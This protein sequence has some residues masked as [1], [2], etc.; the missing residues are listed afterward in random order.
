MASVSICS[1][2]CKD[3][4]HVTK[5]ALQ[6]VDR[7]NSFPGH[8]L[9]SSAYI[10]SQ[11]DISQS[12]VYHVADI[13]W[14]GQ[15]S[16]TFNSF[17]I[18]C[19]SSVPY[20][21]SNEVASHKFNCMGS[22][23]S[24]SES[25]YQRDQY[26]SDSSVTSASNIKRQLTKLDSYFSKLQ[27]MKDRQLGSK[28]QILLE[29]RMI[30]IDSSGGLKDNTTKTIGT[31]DDKKETGLSSLEN[32]FGRLSA[33]IDSEKRSLSSFQRGVSERN[34]ERT[35]ITGIGEGNAKE[36][37]DLEPY[38]NNDKKNL[39]DRTDS[40]IFGSRNIQSLP[41]EDE[42]SD[43]YLI[44]VLAAIDIAVYLFEIASPVN[45]EIEHLSLPLIYGAKI[46]K[47]IL[48]GEW[49]RLLTP[50][51]LHSGFLH[52]ALSCWVLLTYG[53][54]VCKTYGPF[55]FFLMYILGGICGNFT[56]FLHTPELT[57]C[58]TGPE[59]AIIGAW[60]VYQVQNKEVGSKEVSLNMFLKAVIATA[61]SFVLSS[62]GRVDNWT[63]VSAVISGIIFGFLTSPTF[64]FGAKSGR[65]E[66]ITLFKI[67]ASHL[68]PFH[69]L[70]TRLG[71][72]VFSL[73][74]RS[75]ACGVG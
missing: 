32:Y 73:C 26:G 50:M 30:K 61:L 2:Y 72:L 22:G 68:P 1:L 55:T 13:T 31:C 69:G 38:T 28:S 17:S 74:T 46:N 18:N 37:V 65:K 35:S 11:I 43:L 9:C 4:V 47:L 44:S 56:S 24:D 15:R 5:K 64:A 63:H 8:R 7:G 12:T 25:G 67:H 70:H 71:F 62:F 20:M 42:A 75:P 16:E 66:G 51:F 36:E 3:G 53:P 6:L 29:R 21:S 59:F 54:Q 33:K 40:L 57:V 52:V 27:H 23:K 34:P 60:L 48:L 45:S 49:W 41:T 39:E 19:F 14:K 10:A 58:G